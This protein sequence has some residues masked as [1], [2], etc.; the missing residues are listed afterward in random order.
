MRMLDSSNAGARIRISLIT[1]A[2]MVFTITVPAGTASAAG[3]SPG[4]GTLPAQSPAWTIQKSPDTTVSNARLTAVSCAGVNACT[5]V[6]SYLNTAGLNAPLAESL[7]GDRLSRQR[8]PSAGSQVPANKPELSG[9]SCPI[10]GFCEAVG[11]YQSGTKGVSLAYGWNGSAWARQAV[12]APAGSTSA[13]LVQVSCAAATFCEAVGRYSTG[14]GDQLA[15]AA[16]WDG[17]AWHLQRIPNPPGSTDSS[18]RGVSCVSASFCAAA[19]SSQ[20]IGEFAVQWNGTSWQREKLPGTSNAGPVSCVSATFCE[21]VGS[22]G[23]DIWKGRT[24][25]AQ[26]IPI[27]SGAVSGD[28]DSVSCVTTSFCDASGYYTN[29]SGDQLSYGAT[30]DGKTW[31]LLGLPTTID[32]SMLSY[33]GISCVTTSFC[34]AVEDFPGSSGEPFAQGL[35]WNGS[36]WFVDSGGAQA[37]AVPNAFAGVSCISAVYCVA[38]GSLAGVWN[39]TSWKREATA[40]VSPRGVSC[41]STS[42]CMAVGASSGGAGAEEWQ[43]AVWLFESVSGA[44]L[45]AVSCTST[46]FCLAVGEAGNTDVWNGGGWSPQAGASGFTSLSSV[47]C[48]SATFCEATGSGPAGEDAEQWN[49]STWTAQATPAP[50]GG[51]SPSL[52]GISCTGAQSCEAVGSYLSSTSRQLTL[53]EVWDGTSWAAQPTPNPAS[54][55]TPVL[56]S[57]SCTSGSSCTAVGQDSP[58][59]KTIAEV[60]N[61]TAWSL[62]PTPNVS[63]ASQNTLASV[64]CGAAAVCLAVGVTT[65]RGQIEATLAESGD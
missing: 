42:F 56:N 13:D 63:Y 36:L 58:A 10:S 65:D 64:S 3:T 25:T 27:P 2:L 44:V 39:G 16:G 32:V 30:W 43:G 7:N 17:T 61:G 19:G 18:L 41:L 24:W 52:S 45:T 37:G 47:S 38:V 59:N 9:V 40:S 57:V 28:L 33:F 4:A 20:G 5:T 34:Q 55:V 62:Q 60:W 48:A 21:S 51:N 6:G 35:T 14:T 12:A 1:G 31:G 29:S 26:T 53:A 54:S 46:D 23:G 49:G 8:L 50:A 22:G 11:G 15:F